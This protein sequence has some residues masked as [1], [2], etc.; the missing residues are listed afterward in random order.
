MFRGATSTVAG[1]RRIVPGQAPDVVGEGRREHQVL[2]LR[3]QQR[4]DLLDVR[5]EAHVEHP[6]RLVEHEDLD[7]AEVGD[8]LADEVEQPA[9]R[10]DE[11]LDA[12]AERLDLRVHRDAAVDDGRSGAAP[13]GRRSRTLSSTCMASSRVGTRIR[14]RTGWRAGEKL[15]LAWAR[16][17]SR[18]G[19]DEGGGLAGA[20]LGG[21]EDVAALEDERDGRRLD[22][23]GGRIAFLG[24]GAEEIG[25]EAERVEGQ[26]WAPAWRSRRDPGAGSSRR[27]GPD[28]RR[29][30]ERRS[31]AARSIPEIGGAPVRPPVRRRPVQRMV[32]L[33]SAGRCAAILA[34]EPPRRPDPTDRHNRRPP[35]PRQDSCHL[36]GSSHSTAP[37]IGSPGPSPGTAAHRTA[38][39]DP[40][41]VRPRSLPPAAHTDR[42]RAPRTVFRQGGG[43]SLAGPDKRRPAG[44]SHIR[45]APPDRPPAPGAWSWPSAASAGAAQPTSAAAGVKVVVVVGPVGSRPPS[46]IKSARSYAAL[47]RS[48]RRHRRRG[49]Q[50]QRQLDAGPG[51]R[52]GRE[53]LH[54][55]RPRQRPSQPVRRVPPDHQG[56]ARP[57]Q[58]RSTTATTTYAT[59]AR[60][61]SR[62]ASSSRQVPW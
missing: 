58:V 44:V 26:A 31:R 33:A 50:P 59:T 12:G 57:Q 22:R 17:R 1:S 45:S 52:R 54:L 25:R 3:R 53:H 24:D 19:Q 39:R 61:T 20:G 15:V 56:R 27:Q 49:L 8:L 47:A 36:V 55:P 29:E 4:D 34:A 30:S 13:S 9:R 46:Y 60:A 10:R 14:T 38:P 40:S 11:D 62:P 7:L 5:Q 41:H 32:G 42:R 6:V 21:G 37:R 51:G 23:G 48:L 43:K 16:S 2:P 18:I 28:R 35:P